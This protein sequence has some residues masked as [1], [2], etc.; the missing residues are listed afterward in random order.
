MDPTAAAPH[1]P[2]PGGVPRPRSGRPGGEFRPGGGPRPAGS[3]TGAGRECRLQFSYHPRRLPHLRGMVEA[4]LG[5]WGLE[6]LAHDS[7]LIATELC[8]NVRHTPGRQGELALREVPG[9]V[10]IE[11]RD[12]CP[13][14]PAFPL[15][16]PDLFQ[17]GG[18]G[19][20]LVATQATR[21]GAALRRGGKAV[22]AEVSLWTQQSLDF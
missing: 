5:C 3:R 17:E 6:A 19:L 20:F 22:W 12:G 21:I 4:S 18:R 11:V 2:R 13:T 16:P 15:E 7:T 10:R 14:L 8:S 1:P 9:G